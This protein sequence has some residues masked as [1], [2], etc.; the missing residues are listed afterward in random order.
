VDGVTLSSTPWPA[1]AAGGARDVE[2]LIGHTRDEYRLLDAQL[3]A[4]D[5]TGVDALVNGLT[6]TPGAHRYPLS[7]DLRFEPWSVKGS[8]PGRSASR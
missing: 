5:D 4:V 1:L 8:T 7:S 6:P 3:P 2:L